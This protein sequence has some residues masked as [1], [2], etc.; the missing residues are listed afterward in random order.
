MT[1][2]SIG[3]EKTPAVTIPLIDPLLRDLKE[4]EAV[5]AFLE[6][7]KLPSTLL[8]RNDATASPRFLFVNKAFEDMS[9]FQGADLIGESPCLLMGDDTDHQAARSFGREVEQVGQAFT[10]MTHYRKNGTSH[11]VFVLGASVTPVAQPADEAA[12]FAFF[13][14]HLADTVLSAP[15]PPIEKR[16]GLNN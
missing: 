1:H 7:L 14:F 4:S 3:F 12:V 5:S 11:D 8:F 10:T 9:G 2:Q 13:V 6:T 15:R 16:S